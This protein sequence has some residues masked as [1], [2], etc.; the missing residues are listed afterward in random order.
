MVGVGLLSQR[1]SV[2]NQ[3]RFRHRS[4]FAV[5]FLRVGLGQTPGLPPPDNGQQTLRK[6]PGSGA[7]IFGMDRSAKVLV[8]EDEDNIRFIVVAALR[9]GG[10]EVEE[11]SGGRDALQIVRNGPTS[12]DLVVLDVMLP[13][14]DGFEVCRR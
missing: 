1:A 7:T 13:D 6:P 11:V 10:F 2:V 9:L 4:A 12:P 8:V 5:D 14:L 3:P